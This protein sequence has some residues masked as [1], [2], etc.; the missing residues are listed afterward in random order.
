MSDLDL[1]TQKRLTSLTERLHVNDPLLVNR[2]GFLDDVKMRVAEKIPA[3]PKILKAEY[4]ISELQAASEKQ[5]HQ[6]RKSVV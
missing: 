1:A 2:E 3:R 6:D 5:K 4:V